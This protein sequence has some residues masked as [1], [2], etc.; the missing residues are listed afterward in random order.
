MNRLQQIM[1]RKQE[2]RALLEGSEP[3][4]LAALETELRALETEAL[5]IEKRKT[6][7]EG[8]A[9]TAT[10]EARS[11]PGGENP[12]AVDP[13]VEARKKREERGKALKENRSVTVGS[14]NIVLP[15]HDD[16]NIAPTFN[17]VSSLLDRVAV[18]NLPGGESYTKPYEVSGADGG[19]TAE[20]AAYTVADQTFGYA[21]INKTKITA[22]SEESEETQKLPA[23]DYDAVIMRG[24][25]KSTRR[26][27]TKEILIGDGAAGHVVGIF[28][29]NATAIDAATDLEIT[30]IDE[31][32][33][34]EIIY[35]F[36]GSEDVEDVAVLVLNKKDLKT[37]GTLRDA[38]GKKVYNI[39]NNGNTGTIDG[40][41]FI[42]NSACKA[43][44]DAAT[45]AGSYV[46]T[47]GPL[48]NY[49]LAVFSDLD[50][51]RSTDF[52]FSTGM[53]AHKGAI[54]IGGNVCAKNGFLRIKKDDGV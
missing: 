1:Q 14:S 18:D 16:P 23:A 52:K 13:K 48:S 27:I 47:Y 5:E 43:I 22:Y 32:T 3:V 11:I 4:D 53:I 46:M 10:I 36:G 7:A 41:P 15:K 35:S 26:K 50:V 30:A 44:S 37:F 39:V 40:V 12:L 20:G 8:I 42:I 51:Q 38:Q 45:A 17:E 54:F 33:L 31:T 49:T 6:L 19:Y 24:I 2:I 25:S 29:A 9:A 28:S 21:I 34:D